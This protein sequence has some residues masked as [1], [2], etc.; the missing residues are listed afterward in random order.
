MQRG[1]IPAISAVL[2][3][4]VLTVGAQA[5][6]AA[7]KAQLKLTKGRKMSYTIER[8]DSSNW[9]D[10]ERASKSTV[11]YQISID[12]V[13]DKGEA[14]L[15]VAFAS[16]VASRDGGDNPWAFDLAKKPDEASEIDTGIRK[17]VAK[18]VS[19]KIVGGRIAEISGFP[20]I[21]AAEDD[22]TARGRRWRIQGIAGERTLRRDLELI[23]AMAVQGQSLEAGK[24]YQV[25]RE[26]SESESDR[27]RRRFSRGFGSAIAF[28]L[29]SIEKNRAKFS[30]QTVARKR[31]EG[32]EAPQ[33]ERKD[34]SKGEAIVA[35][36]A[37]VLLKLQLEHQSE[38][39][40]EYQGN[41]YNIKRTS[42]VKIQRER[43]GK[44]GDGGRKKDAKPKKTEKTL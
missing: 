13:N 37:G 43:R 24:S 30:L 28:K 4:T 14:K 25:K 12:D 27:R 16:L 3:T 11:K 18:P 35:L 7:P 19:V 6:D 29:E 40:G 21:E 23:L 39:S 9:G 22:R 44:K 10:R 41:E 31:P 15:S 38:I 36:R 32:S 34:T 26:E 1:W 33:Y 42:T 8:T 2:M 5:D 20:E 17:A